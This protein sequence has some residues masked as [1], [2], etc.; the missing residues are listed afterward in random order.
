MMAAER[1]LGVKPAGM[2][3]I[4]LKRG[5]VYAG[6][7]EAQ[8]ADLPHVELPE[9]WRERA[10]RAHAAGG[11]G[12]PRGARGSG[13]RGRATTAASATAATC[14]ACSCG[15]RPRKKRRARRELHRR[16]AGRHR[17]FAANR[18][19]GIPAW[20]P[21][22]DRARPP[23]WWNTF[24]VWWRRAWTRCAFWPSPSP[25]RPP[26]TCARSW[27]RRSTKTRRGA[28][29]WSA[30]GSRRCTGSARGC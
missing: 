20:W 17:R 9:N 29:S 8:V 23:C 18:A 24:T 3:Y 10:R 7:S 25:K 4:G 12:D 5:V 27:P 14:A 2:Y 22:R 28:A 1:A 30:R 26:A 11:G 19:T 21:G 16:S 13:A 15:R 6:W